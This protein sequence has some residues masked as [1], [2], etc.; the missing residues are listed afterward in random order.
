MNALVT[1]A[2]A[3]ARIFGSLPETGTETVQLS[4][5]IGRVLREPIHADRPLPPYDRA[6]MDGI[7]F[8]STSKPPLVLAGLHAAGDPPPR[9]LAPGEAWEIMTGAT[10]P[11]DCDTVVPYEEVTISNGSATFYGEIEPGNFI[12]FA[13]GDAMVGTRLVDT[14]TLLGP[15]EIAIAAS[16]GCSRLVVSKRPVITLITTGDEAVPIEA[17]PE[18]W[19]I[20]QSN[21]PM[22]AALLQAS[23]FPDVHL[24]HVVD[25]TG[26]L[27]QHVATA[28]AKS[29]LLILCGGI[30][31]G[32]R[33]HV[34]GVLESLL[35]PPTFHGVAQRP[36]KPLAFWQGPPPVFALPGNPLSVLAT[37]SHY[38]RPALAAMQGTA[39]PPPTR[40]LLDAPLDPAPRMTWLLTAR[41]N[42]DGTVHPIPPLNSGAFVSV[43]T[44]THLLEIPPGDATLPAGSP[45][46]AHLL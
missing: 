35:G 3:L 1:P 29:D 18:P 17:T 13:G 19:Q 9:P 24:I 27:F 25:D 15:V 37:F 20:R 22:L 44:A 36:G 10:L 6:T 28:L 41:L 21:G 43:T 23:G 5:A 40:L 32:K 2:E 34:R 8:H 39:P 7:A 12:H 14:G 4:A 45:V 11:G 26:L 33:D 38:V 42:P 30:S 31:M 46:T 16:V